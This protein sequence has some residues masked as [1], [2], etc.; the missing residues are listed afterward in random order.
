MKASNTPITEY[1]H[2]KCD[3]LIEDVITHLREHGC[4]KRSLSKG[5][6]DNARASIQAIVYDAFCAHATHPYAPVAISKRPQTYSRKHPEFKGLS[7]RMH[8]QQIYPALL[9]MGYLQRLHG[10]YFDRNTQSGKRELYTLTDKLIAYFG[11]DQLVSEQFSTSVTW[12]DH[13]VVSPES[14]PEREP[15]VIS[16]KDAQTKR[17]EVHLPAVSPKLSVIVDRLDTINRSY[18]KH[19]FDLE[20]PKE[21]WTIFGKG[22]EDKKGNFHT[23]N[24]T[25]RRLYRIFHDHNLE[26]GGRFYGG[27]WQ[28]IPDHYRK[29]I[30]IDAKRTVECDFSGLHSAILYARE[31][32]QLPDDPYSDIAGEQN[33]EIVKR[34]ISAMVNA[35]S[36]PQMPPRNLNIKPTGYS[37][38]QLKARILEFHHPIRHYFFKSAGMWLM[39]HDSE[40]A[41]EVMLHFIRMGYPCLPVHDSFIVHHGLAGEL[42]DKM[43][44]VFAARYHTQPKVKLIK[45]DHVPKEGTNIRECGG[46]WRELMES[47]DTPHNHRASIYFRLRESR[48]DFSPR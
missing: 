26:T 43:T 19:W 27:W 13:L 4:S 31:G 33:R 15:V 18:A 9:E 34:C 47:T 6:R 29:F 25:K 11:M 46:S 14:I 28:E 39:R 16:I 38:T 24:L 10:G 3:R 17:K 8:V 45:A 5:Q 22:W 21:Q 1:I 48:K 7:F 42:E 40:I 37:W 12:F 44:E 32:V 41:E 30:L 23:L 20:L 35:S 2:S 36:E